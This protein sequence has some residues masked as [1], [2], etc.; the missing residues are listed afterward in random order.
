MKT[1]AKTL[2]VLLLVALFGSSCETVS[3]LNAEYE[4][5]MVRIEKMSPEEKANLEKARHEQEEWEWFSYN[6]AGE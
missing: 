4:E 1:T 5:E 3:R 2:A 6:R